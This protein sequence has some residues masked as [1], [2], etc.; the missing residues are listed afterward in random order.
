[1]SPRLRIDSAVHRLLDSIVADRPGSVQPFVDI[2]RLKNVFSLEERVGP[3]AGE[4]VRLE[5]QTYG[6]IVALRGI[7]LAELLHLS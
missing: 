6:E 3:H 1:M 2:T 4:A 5:L 7:L